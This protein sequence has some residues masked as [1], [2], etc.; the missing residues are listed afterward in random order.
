MKKASSAVQAQPVLPVTDLE[1]ALVFYSALGF[2]NPWMHGEPPV[3]GGIRLDS[4]SIQFELV[5]EE[6]LR[7]NS[8]WIQM[9]G[10]EAYCTQAAKTLADLPKTLERLVSEGA[11]M[12]SSRLSALL[13][14]GRIAKPL[15]QNEGSC[16]EFVLEDPFGN[17]V[18]FSEPVRDSAKQVKAENVKI[19]C[20]KLTPE[21]HRV[22]S[23]AVG[24]GSFIY[25]P[26]VPD[27]ISRLEVTMTAEI[28]GRLIGSASMAGDGRFIHVIGD[29]MVL[30]EYQGQ[31]VGSLLMEA[32]D[33]WLE[34]NGARNAFVCLF[35][36]ASQTG[37]Y[38]RFGYA[39]PESGFVGMSKI[40][41]LQDS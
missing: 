25:R 39:G 34:E 4:V 38:R 31:G 2:E 26:N 36:N 23:E 12:P 6:E 15:S 37:Y 18:T 21:E 29:V 14:Q 30:P 41:N 20:R 5:S 40:M 19:V 10:V 28:E 1:S 16:R 24:W 22:L 33:H 35:T 3:K 17:R 13:P 9:N 32:L 27:Q 11:E 7:P 8:L